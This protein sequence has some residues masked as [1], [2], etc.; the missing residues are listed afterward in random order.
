MRK[1]Y[2]Y[3][4]VLAL[5]GTLYLAGNV[6]LTHAAE[7]E[8]GKAANLDTDPQLVGWWKLD[9]TSGKTAADSSKHGHHGTLKGHLS[10]DT[11]SVPGRIGKALKIGGGAENFIEITGYKGITGARPRTVAAWIKT[12][13]P[14]GLLASWGEDEPGRMWVFQIMGTGIHVHLRGGYLYT[15]SKVHDDAWHHVAVVVEETDTPSL[16]NGVKLYTD[17]DLPKIHDIGLLDLYP[18]ATGSN[19][20]VG[21]GR[22]LKGLLDDVRI[23]DRALTPKEIKA[24]FAAPTGRPN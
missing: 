8:K 23:Y 16:G 7:P 14:Q 24:L 13:S 22:G 17:G 21:I 10:F 5:L 1:Q 2:P 6:T 19:L 9:E 15:D 20:N 18:I 12:A 11:D 4:V 3:L